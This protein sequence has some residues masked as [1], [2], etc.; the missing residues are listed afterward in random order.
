M[1]KRQVTIILFPMGKRFAQELDIRGYKN[2]SN[3]QMLA[4]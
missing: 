2:S 1:R 4:N 3:Y